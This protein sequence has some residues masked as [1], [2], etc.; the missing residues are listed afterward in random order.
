MTMEAFETLRTRWARRAITLPALP[1]AGLVMLAAAPLWIVIGWILDRVKPGRCALGLLAMAQLYLLHETAGIIASGWIF[2]RG[3]ADSPARNA[4][5]NARLQDWWAAS[6]M[7][8]GQRLLGFELAIEGA[9]AVDGPAPLLLMRHASML[10]TLIPAITLTRPHG[11]R[12]RYVIKREL[13]WDP[14][15]D[16]NGNRLPN[17]FVRRGSGES[18]AEIAAIVALLD[19]LEGDGV[20]IFPE[21]TRFTPEK[22]ARAIA[23]FRERGQDELARLASELHHTLLPRPGGALALLA[24]NPGL[25]VVI[26][27]HTGFEPT[28]SIRA[29]FD[30]ALRGT[31]VRVGFWR[32]PFDRLPTTEDDRRRWLFDQW[33]RVDAWIDSRRGEAA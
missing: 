14:C 13:L 30:G 26:C 24:A 29:V 12:L 18:S 20:V 6:L 25:D 22:R 9:E 4:A 15:V 3:L 21:G 27:A 11:T 31:K 23:R 19:R 5:R 16:L 28:A 1:I 33:R 10:D 32:I 17:Y 7:R 2:G 8:W